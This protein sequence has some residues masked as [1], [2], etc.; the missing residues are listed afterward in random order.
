MIWI[1]VLSAVV[2]IGGMAFI[3]TAFVP[4][5]NRWAPLHRDPDDRSRLLALVT[6]RF[7][8]VSWA[9]IALLLVTGLLN[10]IHR[11]GEWTGQAARLLA[12]KLVLVALMVVLSG[13]HDFILGP[14]LSAVRRERSA[15]RNANALQRA[16]P[17]LARINLILAL[18]IVY[19]AVLIARV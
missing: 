18:A 3:S 8:T 7:K 12:V 13:L 11:S 19:L 14:R 9:A 5:L 4:G 6:Q 17:W 10:V 1:H 16:V 2:W 15:S